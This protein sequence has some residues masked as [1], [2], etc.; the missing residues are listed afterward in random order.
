MDSTREKS[1]SFQIWA[2]R[3][4]LFLSAGKSKVSGPGDGHNRP[5]SLPAEIRCAPACS[6][7]GPEREQS[8][9]QTTGQNGEN[10]RK[11]RKKKKK[12]HAP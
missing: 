4:F 6:K 3:L 2:N 10:R 5:A 8:N 12:G 1:V 11:K 7:F 9:D